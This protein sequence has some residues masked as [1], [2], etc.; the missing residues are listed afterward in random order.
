METQKTL[1]LSKVSSGSQ[2]LS[3]RQIAQWLGVKTSIVADLIRYLFKTGEFDED[4]HCTKQ[5]I[6]Q[7]EG[8]RRVSRELNCYSRDVCLAVAWRVHSPIG[9]QFRQW[10]SQQLQQALDDLSGNHQDIAGDLAGSN[11]GL[12]PLLT[13]FRRSLL[14]LYEF[15]ARRVNLRNTSMLAARPLEYFEVITMIGELRATLFSGGE[16]GD[17]GIEKGGTEKSGQLEAL[18]V[19]AFSGGSQGYSSIEQKAVHLLWLVIHRQP[20]VEGNLQL[21]ALL[22]VWFLERNGLLHRDDG[23][24]RLQD[25]TLVSMVLLVSR[26]P[27]EDC[28]LLVSL[29]AGLINR[30]N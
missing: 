21:A 15:E 2:W 19:L 7:Q 12:V 24:C 20:F 30:D 1:D 17:F 18:L 3:Q 5:Q 6:E 13:N 14:K 28:D 29:L 11:D 16:P 27:E 10:G 23:S 22:F 8:K 4:E 9:D 26:S 25:N